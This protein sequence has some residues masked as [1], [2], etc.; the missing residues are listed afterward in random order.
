MNHRSQNGYSWDY[1]FIFKVYKASEKLSEKQ[2][3]PT[4][5]IKGI[6]D[7]LSEAGLQTKLYYS[8]QVCSLLCT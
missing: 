6:L 2:K 5:T 1:V 8:V 3:D 7:R 4:C